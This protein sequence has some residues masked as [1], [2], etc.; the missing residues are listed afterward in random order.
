[1]EYQNRGEG[2]STSGRVAW[3]RQLT[4]KEAQLITPQRVFTLQ[5]EWMP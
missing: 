5:S 4:K 2:A 1:M 3:S